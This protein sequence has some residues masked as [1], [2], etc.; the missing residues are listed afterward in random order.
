MEAI[1]NRNKDNVPCDMMAN[2][3]PFSINGVA[4]ND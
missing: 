4:C 2:E 3:Q 1:T